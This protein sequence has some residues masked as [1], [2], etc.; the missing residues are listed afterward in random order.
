M[1][2]DISKDKKVANVPNLRFVSFSQPWKRS[3][4]K[5]I[6]SF[7]KGSGI[8]KSDLSEQ[9]RNCILY[10]QLYTDY[11]NATQV[12]QTTLKT[13][14]NQSDLVISQAGQVLIPASGETHED[15][16]NSV[17]INVPG[18]LIGGDIN[19]LTPKQEILGSFLACC[20][21]GVRKKQIA[22]LAQGDSVVHLNSNNLS[23]LIID[24]PSIDEQARIT[25]F[26]R[27]LEARIEV[28][29]KIIKDKKELKR[30]ICEKKINNLQTELSL[31]DL[32]KKGY[33]RTIKPSE[34][35]PFTGQK[36]YLSTSSINNDGV[37]Q[38]EC[39][40]TYENRPSRACMFPTKNSVWF[41]KMKNTVK[42]FKS[43]DDD[44]KKYVLS[45]GFYGLLCE[46]T[47]MNADWLYHLFKT[48]YFNDQK[49]RFSE[50]S[51]M[52]GIKDNQFNDIKIK[53]FEN[54]LEEESFLSFLNLIDCS[55]QVEIRL[56]E[57]FQNGKKYFLANLFI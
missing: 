14:L 30:G 28:Q 4:L 48:N 1:S 36:E 12:N 21:R 25:T 53:I 6:V 20:F 37:S 8:S 49:D 32:I 46:E 3:P 41:A 19:I 2:N 52:S 18:V 29:N 42:V 26:I 54:K 10:G 56:L 47:K 22:S 33:A 23:K 16:S 40:I 7:S 39:K 9:G 43:T 51:S 24:Y 17:V 44:D 31:N 13:S 57:L 11:S 50:G 34:L 5:S 15:I 55:I 45:T 38:V 27:L 35:L